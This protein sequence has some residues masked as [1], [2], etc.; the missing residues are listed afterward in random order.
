MPMLIQAEEA[1]KK[2]NKGDITQI[3]GYANP[4]PIVLMV[5]EA[6]CTLLNEKTDW[7][8]IKV[9]MMDLNFLDRLKSYQKNNISD[10]ILKKLR[11]Y[12]TKPEFEPQLVGQK[13]AASK[14]LCLWCRA[15][16]NYSKVAKE[17]QPKK[18]KLA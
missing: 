16:D 1:L 17:V 8:N 10:N 15:I 9:V 4:H 12:T 14:S 6:V 3:K 18:K 7:A 5:L 13:N 11:A 2:I